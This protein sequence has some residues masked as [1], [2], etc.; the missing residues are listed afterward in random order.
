M[1]IFSTHIFV[2]PCYLVTLRCYTSRFQCPSDSF[3]TRPCL[4]HLLSSILMEDDETDWF[5]LALS[6]M[7]SAVVNSSGRRS[8]SEAAA[9]FSPDSISRAPHNSCSIC[10]PQ[11]SIWLRKTY[12]ATHSANLPTVRVNLRFSSRK[13]SMP[14]R[15]PMTPARR[16]STSM[17]CES[18][19]MA[20]WRLRS[21]QSPMTVP[22]CGQEM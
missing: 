21:S 13:Q 1:E 19:S 10:S 15:K 5:F 4:R 3:S 9:P 18:A 20:C 2:L 7:R 14:A 8:M 12:S 16:R 22:T 11:S 6:L 17:A